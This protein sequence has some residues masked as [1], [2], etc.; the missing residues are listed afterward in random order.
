M[1][2]N[3]QRANGPDPTTP[4]IRPGVSRRRLMAS[5]V[6]AIIGAGGAALL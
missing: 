4:N 6:S 3:P 1:S 2:D 5:T